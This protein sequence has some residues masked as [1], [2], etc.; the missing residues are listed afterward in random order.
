MKLNW[1]T[2]SPSFLKAKAKGREG[3]RKERGEETKG[4]MREEGEEKRG[5][6]KY[7]LYYLK[8]TC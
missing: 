2:N 6:R 7:C 5:E 1:I 4:K 3:G 8:L